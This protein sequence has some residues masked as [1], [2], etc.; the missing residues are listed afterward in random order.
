MQH[1]ALRL[2]L[3]LKQPQSLAVMQ[4]FQY[5][6]SLFVLLL[7]LSACQETPIVPQ[8]QPENW[9]DLSDPQVGQQSVY[10]RYESNCQSLQKEFAFTGDTLIVEIEK[11]DGLTMLTEH[12]SH[13][14]PMYLQG[15]MT[16]TTR[17][18]LISLGKDILIPD[19]WSSQL[20]FFYGNDTLHLQPENRA[21][22]FQQSCKIELGKDPFIGNE[23]G[24]ISSFEL[25]TIRQ[26]EKTVVSC[27]P[28]MFQLDA[29]LF[30]DSQ[31]LYQSHTVAEDDN[32]SGWVLL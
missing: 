31:Y 29:Y 32:V 26:K 14:S 22:L 6:A 13:G 2:R 28:M 18:E 12:Y 5:V 17:Y 10:L 4:I 7:T 3:S 9:V 24:F 30:Y 21:T 1:F 20:F 27:V 19:R 25:G 11:R 23:I 15:I 16:D 8:P